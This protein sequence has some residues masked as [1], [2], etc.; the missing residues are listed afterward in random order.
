LR[1]ARTR[2]AAIEGNIGQ[3]G[4]AGHARLRVGLHDARDCRGNIEIGL[5]GFFN[6]FG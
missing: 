1:W 4:R 6:D 5:A 2:G 3:Q